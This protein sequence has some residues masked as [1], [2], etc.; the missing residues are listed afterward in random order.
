[1]HTMTYN[2]IYMHSTVLSSPKR[3]LAREKRNVCKY[4]PYPYFLMRE[5]TPSTVV[6]SYK[7]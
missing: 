2:D 1:M 5:D 4:E 6:L 7:I 3:F